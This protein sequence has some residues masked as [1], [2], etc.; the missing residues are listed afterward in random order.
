MSVK[1]FGTFSCTISFIRLEIFMAVVSFDCLLC[2]FRLEGMLSR[3]KFPFSV[4]LKSDFNI[5]P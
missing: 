5:K 3:Y 1:V 2:H 4:T